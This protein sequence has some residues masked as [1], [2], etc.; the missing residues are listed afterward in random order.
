LPKTQQILY[1]LLNVNLK[2]N[3]SKEKEGKRMANK[4]E[5]Y[6]CAHC[7][8][9]AEGKFEGDI[10]PQCSQT[11]WKCGECGFLITAVT[12]PE[13]CPQCKEKCDFLNVTCYTPECGG[14]GHMDPR[15]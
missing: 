1:V 7:G 2:D 13:V 15:L 3:K 6:V 4:E 11:F 12:P 9:T 14:P 8:Y 5:K 10:C